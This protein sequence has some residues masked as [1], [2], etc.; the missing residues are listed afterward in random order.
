MIAFV[1]KWEEIRRNLLTLED[2]RLSPNQDLAEYY[3]GMIR[4]GSCFVAYTSKGKTLFG[5]SRFIGY[6]KNSRR[7]HERNTEKD[8]RKT[9][10]AIQKVLDT[11]F[12]P[13]SALEIHFLKFCREHDIEPADK[14]RKYILAGSADLY[15]VDFL[16]HDLAQIKGNRTLSK[17]KK[18]QLVQARIGQGQFRSQLLRIWQK[19]PVTGC[20]IDPLLC[21]S[22]IKPWRACSDTERLDPFN[23]LLLAPN[24]DCA[25]DRGLITFAP[26]GELILSSALKAAEAGRLGIKKG[27]RIALHKKN[28]PYLEYHRRS[29]FRK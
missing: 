4:L 24:L 15:D 23:G 26:T 18:Q 10:P 6:A 3:R 12:L 16:I 19:C 28:Q 14:K 27:M 11:K 25:F 9:N 8:G 20:R 1:R 7:R 2:Y 13:N 22:H 17:T 21:A 29:V 5:P